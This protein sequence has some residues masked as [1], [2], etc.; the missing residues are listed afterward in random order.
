MSTLGHN[1]GPSW[2]SL[3]TGL[4]ETPLFRV[5]KP[6]GR[7]SL[8]ELKRVVQLRDLLAE[9][10]RGIHVHAVPNAGKRGFKAQRQAKAEGMVAGVFDLCVTWPGPGVAWCEMKG[11]ADR[12]APAVHEALQQR[13]SL[14]E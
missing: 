6:D 3:E 1:G 2:A 9:C 10:G 14:A 11:Y 13:C 7:K 12:G 5:E 8:S 4:Y